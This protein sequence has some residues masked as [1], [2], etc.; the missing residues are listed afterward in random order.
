MASIVTDCNLLEPLVQ[1]EST[2]K[3]RKKSGVVLPKYINRID[4]R[5]WYLRFAFNAENIQSVSDL[6]E[7]LYKANLIDYS[8]VHVYSKLSLQSGIPARVVAHGIA[9]VVSRDYDFQFWR[10]KL[11]KVSFK[12][13][14]YP[15][16]SYPKQNE[17]TEVLQTG[18]I[19]NNTDFCI[20]DG[21]VDTV[22]FV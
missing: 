13:S 10:A 19:Q 6:V 17:T 9:H 11:P 16:N 1:N 18:V 21:A 22:N 5:G 4:G 15:D 8:Y 2:T 3:R 20:N 7:S 12:L 14:T